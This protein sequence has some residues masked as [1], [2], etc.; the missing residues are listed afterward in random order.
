MTYPPLIPQLI[1][2]PALASLLCMV[3]FRS[4]AI[5]CSFLGS[6]W[7]YLC[8]GAKL[9]IDIILHDELDT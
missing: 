9:G 7:L 2:F 8:L 5:F 4:F 3:L 1:P 6:A